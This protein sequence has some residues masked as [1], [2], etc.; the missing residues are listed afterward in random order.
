MSVT[1]PEPRRHWWQGYSADEVWRIAVFAVPAAII[2]WKIL[3]S[4]FGG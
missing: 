2:G 3:D 4:I 1:S